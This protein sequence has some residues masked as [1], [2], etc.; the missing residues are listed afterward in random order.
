MITNY[1]VINY[2]RYNRRVYLIGTIDDNEM[3]FIQSTSRPAAVS[4]EFIDRRWLFFD[5][6]CKKRNY[7]VTTVGFG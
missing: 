3:Y 2:V 1:N 4:K 7:R 6:E 5:K